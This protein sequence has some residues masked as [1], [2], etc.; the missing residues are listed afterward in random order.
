MVDPIL[1]E[2]ASDETETEKELQG[3]SATN[4]IGLPRAQSYKAVDW[5]IATVQRRAC[6]VKK[7]DTQLASSDEYTEAI[8]PAD[9]GDFGSW[10]HA[11]S[12]PTT[13]PVEPSAEE[14]CAN[15]VNSLNPR[16][17]S[18]TEA[19]PVGWGDFS[20]WIAETLLKG[21]PE[22]QPEPPNKESSE[23]KQNSRRLELFHRQYTQKLLHLILESEFEF[24]FE[25]LADA[26]VRDRLKENA[27]ATKQWLNDLFLEHFSDINIT[28]GILRIISHFPYKDIVP[29]GPTIALAALRHQSVEVRECGIRALENWGT[30]QCLKILQ[31]LH[32]PEP[33]LADYVNQIIADMEESLTDVPSR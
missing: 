12:I 26:F 6:T 32:C 31:H 18:V 7:S 19:K 21:I 4:A 3:A 16:D 10:T 29:Q 27:M 25:T 1:R 33:W 2:Q 22:T 17:D 8:T 14:G 28:T 15:R 24:G 9:Y 20:T 30:M 13:E 23:N 11:A 5:F